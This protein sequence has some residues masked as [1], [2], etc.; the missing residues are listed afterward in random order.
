ML[1]MVTAG[2]VAFWVL[3][4]VMILGAIGMVLL[5][6]PVHSALCLAAVMICLAVQ[7]FSLN[8]PFLGVAQII[9]Y[10]G[11]VLMLF[12]F[13]MMLIG[14]DAT[15]SV[16]ET[17]RGQRVAATLAAVGFVILVVLAAGQVMIGNKLPL[18]SPELPVQ[19]STFQAQDTIGQIAYFVFVRYVFVFELTSALLIVAAVGAMV[20]AHRERFVEKISQRSLAEQ[21][22]RRYAETGEHPGALPAPGVY[23][24]HNAIDAPALLPDGSIAETS[25]SPTLAARGSVADVHQIAAA[26]DRVRAAIDGGDPIITNHPGA[27]ALESGPAGTAGELDRGTGTPDATEPGPADQRKDEQ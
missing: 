18:S 24:R 12:L 1:P 26:A 22:M 27:A 19:L 5:R 14:V 10:T 9:V 16:V 21:R 20:L 8:A 7:Y 17:I 2:E 23:A 15:D 3:A 4:P 25:I 13:V 11:A 6:K